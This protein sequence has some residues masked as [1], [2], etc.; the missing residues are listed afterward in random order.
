MDAKA[1]WPVV[2]FI[3]AGTRLKKQDARALLDQ[4]PVE[5]YADL[6]LRATTWDRDCA[7]KAGRGLSEILMGLNLGVLTEAARQARFPSGIEIEDDDETKESTAR[8]PRLQHAAASSRSRKS[9][10][11]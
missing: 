10:R 2:K 7:A 1:T 9:T 5:R 3:I 8:K 11:R 4:I 6:Y